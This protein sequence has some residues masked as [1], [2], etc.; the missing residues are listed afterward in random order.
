MAHIAVAVS[1][2]TIGG[3]TLSSSVRMVFEGLHWRKG[4]VQTVC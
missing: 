2:A 4:E 3:G 1:A